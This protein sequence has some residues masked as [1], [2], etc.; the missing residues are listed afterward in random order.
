MDT[1]AMNV[2]AVIPARYG[3]TRFPAKAL[4]EID[5]RTLIQWV[6]EGT[7]EAKM[8]QRIIV[9]TDHPEIEKECRRLGAEVAMTSEAHTSGTDRVAEAVGDLQADWILNVQGD[10]IL[11]RG[12]ILDEFVAQL[13]RLDVS[14]GMATLARKITEK[15]EEKDSTIVKVVTDLQGKAM[16]FSRAVI[17]FCRDQDTEVDYWHHLGIYAY[18]PEVLKKLVNLPPSPLEKIEKLEQLRALQNGIAIQV[19]ATNF[20]SIGVDTPQDIERVRARLAINHQPE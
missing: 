4:A 5:G 13:Q 17:P 20:V 2:L 1:G 6:W 19:I 12:G 15:G 16:Y 10:E 9:A 8:I 3:S 7:R 18:R 11:I 14:V